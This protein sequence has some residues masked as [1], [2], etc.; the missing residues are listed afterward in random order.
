MRGSIEAIGSG[1]VEAIEEMPV[2]VQEGR[3]TFPRPRVAGVMYAL[4]ALIALAACTSP[5]PPPAPQVTSTAESTPLPGPTTAPTT[6]TAPLL[7]NLQPRL[8]GFRGD[9]KSEGSALPRCDPGARTPVPAEEVPAI[10]GD[11]ELDVIGQL[12][13]HPQ[14][15]A[16]RGD[17]LYI[18]VGP[19]V[20]VFETTP[21][22]RQVAMSPLLPGIVKGLAV[23]DRLLAAA[24]GSSGLALLDLGSDAPTLLSTLPL[25]GSARAVDMGDGVAYVAAEQGGLV[26]VDVRDASQP[27]ALATALGGDSVL[28]VTATAGTLLVAAGEAGLIV[29]DL[30]DPGAPAVAGRIATG[31]YA[32]AVAAD[33]GRAYVA[34]G[35]GGLRIVDLS[36]RSHPRLL[37]SVPTAG[38]AHDVAVD[39]DIAFVA[40][41]SQGLLIADVT[42]PGAPRAVATAPLAG[43]QAIQLV[44][45]SDLAFVID[46]FEG[47]EI[48]GVAAPAAPRWLGT[49]QPLLEG[50][51]A[52]PA[53][54]RL[55]VA[56]GRSG[57]RVVDASDPT[58]LRDLGGAPTVSMANAVA[59]VGDQV[60]VSTWPEGDEAIASLLTIDASDP[61]QP[62]AEGVFVQ[63]GRLEH[64]IFP[65][66][67][68][69]FAGTDRYLSGWG[70][71]R[72]VATSGPTVAYATEGGVLLVD[73]ESTPCEL[74]YFQTRP[75]SAGGDETTAVAIDGK[76]LFVGMNARA[77][78]GRDGLGAII[79]DISETRDPRVAATIRSETIG[80]VGAEGLLV[81]GR[82]LYALGQ[83][84]PS[85]EIVTVVDVDDPTRPLTVGSLPFKASG[86]ALRGPSALAFAAG[87]LFV[88]AGDAGL[89]AL[90]VSDPRRPRVAGRLDV[91]G[92]TLSVVSDGR[93]L[94]VGSDEAGLLVVDPRPSDATAPPPSG[95]YAGPLWS[96]IAAPLD[97]PAV[98]IAPSTSA[99][100][101]GPADCVVTS[102][103]DDGP[104]SLR[105]CLGS[106]RPGDAVGFDPAV[107]S[108][109]QPGT[110]WLESDLPPLR[111][112]LTID[113]GGGVVLDGGGG[114]VWTSFQLWDAT[115]V[116]IRGLQIRGFQMGLFVDGRGTR[117]GH[118]IEGNVISGNTFD[119]TLHMTSGNRVAD[120]YVGLD[121][122]GTTVSDPQ[123]NKGFLI[124]L[125]S[126]MNLI[127]GNLFG[128]GVAVTDPGSHNNSFVGNRFGIDVAGR[129]LHCHCGLSFD[130]PFNRVGGLGPGEA[131]IY[132]GGNCDELEGL[133]SR[134]FLQASD[135]VV[136]SS[137]FRN[138]WV[139]GQ[140][141]D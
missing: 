22:L 91:L 107:F 10:S 77:P 21:T 86:P 3:D 48:V 73:A 98:A 88:A 44:V 30:S 32:F 134:I 37:G 50:W 2:R 61:Q 72:G 141:S 123:A 8:I 116:T 87:H 115:G 135:N 6:T 11:V 15:V 108:P 56:G 102:T 113:G 65:W 109:E 92:R 129:P 118:T 137:D 5:Q 19:R 117:G 28:G 124:Q 27:R 41:G 78:S 34:D 53:G 67:D 59:A 33:G 20:L 139:S 12:G 26:T 9:D 45:A 38:W 58:Q 74:S 69:E 7:S 57:L 46:P 40:A 99:E 42:D 131:N 125:G 93:H 29:L 76:H 17:R 39:G 43:R 16:I 47:L 63:Q 54:D 97:R 35:W 138:I 23:R 62:E 14:A 18:G 13:G 70:P 110:I 103:D 66:E 132:A 94:Y 71:A 119:L 112:G 89:V 55:F 90:D 100:R 127:E 52:S 64:A 133:C 114:K 1:L 49:W 84:D 85:T 101:I 95:G 120:N 130:Q 121:A 104:G 31:G 105:Q 122:T 79:L 106:A 60:L 140:S 4:L 25:Q 24:L 128:V 36:D 96:G 83:A 68:S 81:N 75:Y 82:W 51:H 80:G 111:S 126:S 136:L